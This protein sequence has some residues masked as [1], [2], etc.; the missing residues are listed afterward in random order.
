MTET[1]NKRR[2]MLETFVAAN[3]NDAFTRYAL[4][5]ECANQGDHEAA[6][7][8]FRQL[9]SAHPEY[10]PGYFHYG[11]LLARMQHVEE[12]RQILAAGVQVAHKRGDS[13]AR[14]EME[15]VLRELP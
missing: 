5:V 3:P 10:V 2:E 11:Q 7:D 9:L 12:A 1:R 4:A 8:H 15:A 6:V 14:D 13:H